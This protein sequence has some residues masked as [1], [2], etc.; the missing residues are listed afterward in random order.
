MAQ[1]RRGR[2]P[3]TVDPEASHGARLGFEI[4]TRR[5]E[6]D[7]TL[8]ALGKLAAYTA[9]YISEVERA[10]TTPALPFVVA[11]E[12][13]LD[14]HGELEPLLPAAFREREVKRQERAAARHAARDPSLPCE[15]HSEAVGDDEDVEPTNRRDLL[16][17]GAT[18][19]L[20]AAGVA[21]TPPQVRQID[22]EL[23]SH[24]ERLLGVL[25][26]HDNAFGP[27]TVQGVVLS[28]L[29]VIADHRKAAIG[30]LRM[31]LMR[32]ESYWSEFAAWLAHDS[33]DQ[34]GRDALMNRAL[35]LAREA[36]YPDMLAWA[37]ARQA[38]WSDAPCALRLAEVGLRTSRAS[39]YTRAMCATRAAYAHACLGD[40]ASSEQSIAVAERLAATES[41]PLPPPDSGMTDLL[42]RRWEAR[43][44]AVMKPSRALDMYDAIL[45]GQPRDWV[46]ERGIYTACLA[47]ACA[48]AGELD[49]ARAEGAK[50][51]AIAKQTRSATAAREIRRLKAVL[52]AV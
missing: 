51:L 12:R 50:A 49:R 32:V 17:A 3:N 7:L 26:C 41:R 38:Q 21:T 48:D 28:E 42:V 43:C 8:N 4:R 37:R 31:E 20:G 19:A 30:E 10:K 40:A 39:A 25:S 15:D 35:H 14:A 34:R 45:R 46:R 5:I 6:R 29:R 2:P 44:W 33:G 1:P 18:A 23:P 27:P 47:N 52:R 22:P 16:G 36:D 24:W 9:Q 11:C 13:A